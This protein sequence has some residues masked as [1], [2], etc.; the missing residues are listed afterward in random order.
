MTPENQ[1][2]KLCFLVYTTK[3]YELYKY[4][5]SWLNKSFKID[6]NMLRYDIRFPHTYKELTAEDMLLFSVSQ[7]HNNIIYSG[8]CTTINTNSYS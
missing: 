6:L 4:L 1:A 3:F 8:V 2:F 5:T 7:T